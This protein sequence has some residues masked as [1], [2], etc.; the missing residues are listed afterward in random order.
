M[1]K[2]FDDQHL[3]SLVKLVNSSG[4]LFA[5]ALTILSALAVALFLG[6]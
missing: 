5:P 4:Y 3:E 1:K 2:M 6:R